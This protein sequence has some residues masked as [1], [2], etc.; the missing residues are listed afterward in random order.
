MI[1]PQILQIT[2]ITDVIPSR[3][4]YLSHVILSRSE[5]VIHAAWRYKEAEAKNL[6]APEATCRYSSTE[7]LRYRS[8]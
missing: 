4:G 5:V 6:G 8:E 2:Q 1:Y 3:S 7:I